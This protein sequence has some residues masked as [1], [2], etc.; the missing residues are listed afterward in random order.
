MKQTMYVADALEALRHAL[1]TPITLPDETTPEV[2][3]AQ[4]LSLLGDIL[5]V[6]ATTALTTNLSIDPLL[7]LVAELLPR[8]TEVHNSHVR[9]S[10]TGDEVKY[11]LRAS[12]VVTTTH[13]SSVPDFQK[14]GGLG[15]F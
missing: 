5:T 1:T 14:A 6:P 11:Q 12:T 7:E 10:L 3:Y 13:S 8:D 15:R 2:V 9:A 4:L